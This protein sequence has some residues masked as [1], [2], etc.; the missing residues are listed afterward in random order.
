MLKLLFT[1][2]TRVKL[3]NLLLF[4]QKELHLRDIARK[5][6]AGPILASKELSNL[7]K[8]N[9]VKK[10]K[11]ANSLFYSINQNCLILPELK[12]IFI[13]TDYLGEL[14]K[15]K[16]KNKAKYAFIY[17]SFANGTEK[18][19]SDIDLFIVSEISENELIKALQPLE[20][21]TGREINYVLWDNKTFKDRSF[22][23]HHLLR[24][25]NKNKIIMLVGDEN[26]FRAQVH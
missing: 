26:E 22:Q 10:T 4:S 19:N 25:I 7:E 18:E 17:G 16:L 2:K 6:Q 15:N 5:I 20:K 11:K 14:L 9:L 8:L 12:S 1:S 23:G 24:T 3:L 21:S 13:K